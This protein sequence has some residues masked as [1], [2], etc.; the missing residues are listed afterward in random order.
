[1]SGVTVDGNDI[2]MS[3]TWRLVNGVDPTTGTAY[4]VGT[5]DGG[6]GS[7]PYAAPGTPGLSPLITFV[8][9]EVDPDDALPGTNPELLSY[10]AGGAGTRSEYNYKLYVHQGETGEAGAFA[11]LDATDISGSP[12]DDYMVVKTV[13]ASTVQF[14]PQKVGGQYIGATVNTSGNTSPRVLSSVSIPAQPFAWRPRCFATTTV[15]GTANT[16]VDLLARVGNV[17]TG[18]QVG[19]AKGLAGATP[20]PLVL[21]PGSPSGSEIPG[22]Y[23]RIASGATTI[24]YLVAEQKNGTSDAWTTTA[25]DTTFWVEIAPLPYVTPGS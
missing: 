17:G 14:A 25:A 22:T 7:I 20:S 11:F 5:P 19:Y 13:G 21:I 12:T 9:E 2:V 4:L 18:H 16:R 10:V 23:G 24:I 8:M 3:G 6:V 1:M 15:S